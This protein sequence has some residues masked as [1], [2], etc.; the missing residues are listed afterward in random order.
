MLS[1]ATIAQ[2]IRDHGYFA[3]VTVM[4][5]SLLSDAEERYA[6]F[7]SACTHHLG[8][9]QRFKGHLLDPWL[10]DLARQPAILDIVTAL[11]GP[12]VLLW[13]SDFFVKPPAA[14]GFVSFHQDSTYAGLEP[15]E[16]EDVVNVWL[17]L[18]P[19]TVE[20]GCLQV[21]PDTHRLGQLPHEQVP[22]AD[23]MLFFGQTVT[24]DAA[25]AVPLPL[26][27][28]Q[29]SLHSMRAVHGSGP[30]QATWPRIGL[31]LRYIAPWVRQTKA[32]DSATLI[33]GQDTYGH[34][35]LEPWPESPFSEAALAVFREA[36]QRPSAL[37]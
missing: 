17:A 31:V 21:I 14:G 30:N 15:P 12:N 13:S 1:A 25:T 10:A 20:A 2:H 22:D 5:P 9:P 28:G 33:C 23:N 16:A 8:E 35:Q 37:G 26:V 7:Q 29:A 36:V 34:Y 18:T 4:A 19:S 11:L 27:P 24:L 6:A 32:P 3:P